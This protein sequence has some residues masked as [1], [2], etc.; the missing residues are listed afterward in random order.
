MPLA[1]AGD[2]ATKALLDLAEETCARWNGSA[3][4]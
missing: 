4:I 1:F 3:G 2:D